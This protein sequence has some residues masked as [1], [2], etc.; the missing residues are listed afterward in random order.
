MNMPC[1]EQLKILASY[2]FWEQNPQ[3]LG[4]IRHSYLNKFKKCLNNNLIKVITGQRRV[5]KSYLIRQLI[6]S[7]ISEQGVAAKNTLYINFEN[8]KFS[9][10]NSK[11][12][13]IELVDLYFKE[14]KPEG[15]VYFFFDEIQNLHE[16]EKVIN[17]FHADHTLDIEIF[18]TGSNSKLLSS[19]LATF[20]TGRYI[21]QQVFP[22]SYHEYLGFFKLN[23]NRETFMK[24]L[25][26]SQLSATY[27]LNDEETSRL[28]IKSLKDSILINDIIKRHKIQNADLLEKIF[29]FLVDNIG[30][31]FSF[32]AIAKKL[33][34]LSINTNIPTLSNYIRYLEESF[35]IYGVDRYDT[36][37]KKIFES[38][39]KYYLND[40]GFKNYL[41]SSFN[42]VLGKK[43]ENYVF[44]V[45]NSLSYKLYVG[46]VGQK[47]VDFVAE[48]NGDKR[49]F[50]VA[51]ALDSEKVIEREYN[52]LEMLDDH[53]QKYVV[54]L[55]E[56][57]F[58]A[59]NGIKH[60][61]AWDFEDFISP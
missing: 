16:W 43:L 20:L 57:S 61:N 59:R 21:T 28:F 23:K 53:W 49:Y 8:E 4:F 34:E 45:L 9:F 60:I 29:L 12:K 48:L 35:L 5:G 6:N 22:F 33:K 1:S 17:S 41:S 3:K 26:S 56:Q 39:R 19:E 58:G 51:Y 32:N 7:L 25:L 47:E 37:G 50:Q 30:G 15:K 2:N 36:K 31:L 40:L 54:S 46:V 55:D 11:E 18:V 24:Y 14:L 42:P 38:E 27:E 44:N 13:F 52:S 10:L